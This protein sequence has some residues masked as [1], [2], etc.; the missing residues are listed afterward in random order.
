MDDDGLSGLFST[1][2]GKW[3]AVLLVAIMGQQAMLV[4][5]HL[6]QVL[7]H[8][9]YAVIWPTYIWYLQLQGFTEGTCREGCRWGLQ[10]QPRMP[11]R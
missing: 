1:D 11:G 6:V 3:V 4:V 7:Q 10:A 2:A 5:A 9:L 8:L